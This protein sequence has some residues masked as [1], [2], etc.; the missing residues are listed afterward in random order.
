[1]SDPVSLIQAMRDCYAVYSIQNFF[2]YGADLEIRYGKKH[3][4]CG[5]KGWYFPFCI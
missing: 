2:E 3:G 5:E 1:M 4:G